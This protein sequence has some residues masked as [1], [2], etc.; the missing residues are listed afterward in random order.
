MLGPISLSAF[1]EAHPCARL[2]RSAAGEWTLFHDGPTTRPGP[3][4]PF[5]NVSFEPRRMRPDV[6]E[7]LLAVGWIA[8][9]GASAFETATFYA[10][11][12]DPAEAERP[13]AAPDREAVPAPREARPAFAV[14]SG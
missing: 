6:C 10:L 2:A 11:A 12:P 7:R 3:G 5:V 14:P 4:G 13:A 8:R 1:L 9:C